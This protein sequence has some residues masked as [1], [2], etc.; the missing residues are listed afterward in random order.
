MDSVTAKFLDH[1][2]VGLLFSGQLEQREQPKYL[3][4]HSVEYQANASLIVVGE[5][6]ARRKPGRDPL[7]TQRRRT[8]LA[9]SATPKAC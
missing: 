4:A 7:H 3:G 9:M 5:Y 2:Y 1:L 8:V 6:I